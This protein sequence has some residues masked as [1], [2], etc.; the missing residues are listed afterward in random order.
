MADYLSTLPKVLLQEIIIKATT[1]L[2]WRNPY[3][4]DDPENT[5]NTLL[6]IRGT[7]KTL[8]EASHCS[9]V[10]QACHLEE[11]PNLMA[12]PPE[13]A[14]FMGLLFVHRNLDVLFL[15]GIRTMF[16]EGGESRG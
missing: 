15:W 10:Y 5:V 1:R 16:L 13:V 6:S 3:V 9:E 14:K 2:M 8:R 11:L 4:Q 7:C 12:S